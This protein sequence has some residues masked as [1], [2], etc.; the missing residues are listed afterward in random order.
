MRK[1]GQPHKNTAAMRRCNVCG[2]KKN[3]SEFRWVGDPRRTHTCVRCEPHLEEFYQER[4]ERNM[5]R[6]REYY[7][8][9]RERELERARKRYYEAERPNRLAKAATKKPLSHKNA[10]RAQGKQVP[11]KSGRK[12]TASERSSQCSATDRPSA[13]SKS[14]SKSTYIVV[15][16]DQ[17]TRS[18]VTRFA[19]K[20]GLPVS[21]A[22]R[23]L[24]TEMLDAMSR[25]GTLKMEPKEP[26]VDKRAVLPTIQKMCRSLLKIID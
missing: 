2:R 25:E 20:R 4:R 13:V 8:E 12:K 1:Q 5:R 10:S 15:R 21:T 7:Y 26:V 17:E 11:S 6:K 19:S 22:V 9:N 14:G 23:L 16:V 24:V 3:S 18:A